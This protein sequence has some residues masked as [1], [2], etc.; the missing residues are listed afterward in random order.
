MVF[1]DNVTWLLSWLFDDVMWF[2]DLLCLNKTWL[3]MVYIA[4]L[5][6]NW[7]KLAFWQ[8]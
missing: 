6:I 5:D 1:S 2:A 3:I 7:Y 8:E 4:E